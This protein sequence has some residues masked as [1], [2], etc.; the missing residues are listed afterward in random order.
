MGILFTFARTA[1][2]RMNAENAHALT[3]SALKAGQ[4]SAF[5]PNCSNDKFANLATSILGLNFPNPV[6][7]AAGFDKNGEVPDALMKLGFGYAEIGTVTPNPQ[8]GNPRPRVFRLVDD[9][10]VINRL[11]FNNKGH[12]DVLINLQARGGSGIIGIN[13]GA[14]KDSSDFI[15]DYEAGIEK[16]WSVADYFTVNISS[17]NTPGLR[18]LQ[19]SE[20]LGELLKRIAA[21]G[22]KMAGA[23]KH[24]PPM[25]LKIAPD[26][27]ESEMDDIAENILAASIDGLVI[28]NTTLAR[29]NLRRPVQQSGGLSGRPVFEHSTIVL[30][31]MRQRLGDDI[32]IIG[33]GGIDSTQAAWEKFEAGA[34]LLQL[35]TA[36]IY[37]GP[38]LIN[39]I[40]RGLS[41]KLKNSGHADIKALSGAKTNQWA[42]KTLPTGS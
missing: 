27:S 42:A 10:A 31:K 21:S 7:M 2:F 4:C 9:E 29:Y 3:I 35:Y 34:S 15:C 24:N 20:A 8:H 17:P 28:S 30:A 19:A 33:V 11:G 16:F 26:L 22:D 40:C 25:F 41:E 23:S 6:G 38:G 39:T 13:I 1:M 18:N 14:N 36:M 12:E 37:H 32:P 5:M